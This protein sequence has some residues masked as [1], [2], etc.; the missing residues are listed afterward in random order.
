[1]LLPAVYRVEEMSSGMAKHTAVFTIRQ[2]GV[3]PSGSSQK[4]PEVKSCWEEVVARDIW[5]EFGDEGDYLTL[6]V[7][8]DGC[9][10]LMFPKSP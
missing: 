4:L 3:S 6:F 10:I 2:G 7:K 9:V 5:L 1:M 8:A